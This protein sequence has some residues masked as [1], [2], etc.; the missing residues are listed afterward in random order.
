MQVMSALV[1]LAVSWFM[2]LFIVLPFMS[3]SQGDEGEI[4]P[5]THASAPANFSAKR[6]AW[7]TTQIAIPIWI[8]LVVVIVMGWVT[9][10]DFDLFSRFGP[11][12]PVGA[13]GG[14]TGE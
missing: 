14:G 13:G 2:T 8:V 12:E 5:G 9:L 3:R 7:R 4:V 1:L 6:A 11:Q 10:D